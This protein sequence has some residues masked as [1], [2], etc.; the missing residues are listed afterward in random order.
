MAKI[1]KIFDKELMYKKIMPTS[2]NK[3]TEPGFENIMNDSSNEEASKNGKIISIS[4]NAI[5]LNEK[6]IL[7]ENS[8]KDVKENKKS[9]LKKEEKSDVILYNVMEKLVMEKLDT[10]LKKMICCRCDRCKEDIIALSLNN[11]RPMY[12]VANKDEINNK[13]EQLNKL[14]LEVTTAVLKAVLAIRKNPRH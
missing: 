6:P 2:L 1:K 5:Y 4:A 13:I 12:I 9:D 11:L 10:T 14:G 8:L 3:N 7:N